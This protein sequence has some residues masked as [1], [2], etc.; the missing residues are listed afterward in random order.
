[1]RILCD[2]CSR[3]ISGTVKKIAGSF[4]FHPNCFAALVKEGISYEPTD[5]SFPGRENYEARTGVNRNG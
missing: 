5:A 3:P 4:N 1:M 2:R